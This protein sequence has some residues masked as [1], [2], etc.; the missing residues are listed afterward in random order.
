MVG[1][2]TVSD[3]TP[4]AVVSGGSSGI[5]RAFV[6]E[7]CRRSYRVVTCRRDEAKLRRLEAEIPSVTTQ[8]CDMAD[9]AAVQAFATEVA[10]E[11]GSVEL[12]VSNACGLREIDLTKRSCPLANLTAE[13]RVNLE[14]P[15]NLVAAFL[16]ALRTAGKASVVVVSSTTDSDK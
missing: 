9:P 13:I 5:G 16:P 4:T 2:S 12:L 14:G 10:A 6:Q 11:I 8:I 3:K 15:I 1:V 7:L